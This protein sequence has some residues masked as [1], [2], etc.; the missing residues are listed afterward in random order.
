MTPEAGFAV[1]RVMTSRCCLRH[2][3]TADCLCL[4]LAAIVSQTHEERR[5]QNNM[6]LNVIGPTDAPSSPASHDRFCGGSTTCHISP[7]LP[8]LHPISRLMISA[9]ALFLQTIAR[10][11][12]C[13]DGDE[14]ARSRRHPKHSQLSFE[15]SQH[16]L[17]S[18][19]GQDLKDLASRTE[20]AMES[21]S[22]IHPCR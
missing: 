6:S 20:R 1:I 7:L 21:L 18:Q 15:S 16:C 19:N 17:A 5:M 10:L 4:S 9:A 22:E 14:M 11:T 8:K 12:C 2:C 3:Q 13:L